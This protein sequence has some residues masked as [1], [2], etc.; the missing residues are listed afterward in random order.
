MKNPFLY[1]AVFV[2]GTLSASLAQSPPSAPPQQQSSKEEAEDQAK[3]LNLDKMP[4]F[5]GISFGADFPAKD[6]K[7]EQD[8]G[9]LK[10]YRKSHDKILMGP[11]LLEAVLYYVFEGKFYGVALHTDDGQDSLALKGILVNAFGTG[12]DSEDN[13]PS[14]IWMAKDRGA[15]F[16]LN[17]STGE[18]SAFIFDHKLHNA[19]L[20]EQSQ[21]SQSAAKQLIQ[22]KP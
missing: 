21:A 18:G 2:I 12:V 11:A 20:A 3:A 10:I 14:T 15:L 16:D 7:L 4:G 1:S 8:R 22:G 6:F 5:E 17:T 13:G 19:C 9:A